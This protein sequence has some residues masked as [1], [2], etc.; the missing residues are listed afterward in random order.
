[1]GIDATI[2]DDVPRERFERIA[3]AYADRIRLDDVLGEGGKKQPAAAISAD[4]VA[5]L[6]SRVRAAIE[7]EPL[8][9]AALAEKFSAEGF[10][11]VARALG[12]L[13]EKDELWQD[14]L[15][16][17]CLTGSDFAAVPPAGRK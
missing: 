2:G 7:Q 3:Y 6:S 13:H 16:R 11:A 10:Q 1:M 8:Y 17:F 14:P 15:G 4:A 9:F 12:S 5:E